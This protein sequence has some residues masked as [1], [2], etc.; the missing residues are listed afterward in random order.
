M[1]MMI[2]NNIKTTIDSTES[3]KK[4]LELV[5]A[6]L[7]SADKSLA[8]TLISKLTT[9]KFTEMVSMQAHIIEMTNIAARLRTLGMAIDDSLMQ[10]ILNSL[11]PKYGPFQIN[12]N[13]LKDKWNISELSSMLTQE[14]ARLKKQEGGNHTFNLVSLGALKVKPNKFKKKK[15]PTKA[16]QGD[17]KEKSAMK[18]HFCNKKDTFRRIA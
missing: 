14:E 8:G 16:S 3:A 13:S 10:F 17:K 11:H 9:M 4:Y 6:R 1:W 2:A 5:E 12:Y 7:C 15:E 18:C